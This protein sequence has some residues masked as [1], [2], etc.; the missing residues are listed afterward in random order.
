MGVESTVAPRLSVRACSAVQ[1]CLFVVDVW[2][3][4]FG[5][6]LSCQAHASGAYTP[7]MDGLTCCVCPR[8]RVESRTSA[9]VA[10]LQ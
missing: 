7:L 5:M 9:H 3:L 4:A 1:S 6:P 8:S 2:D 10:R